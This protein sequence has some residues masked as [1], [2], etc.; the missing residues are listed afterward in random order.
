MTLHLDLRLKSL[1]QLKGRHWRA[2]HDD[3]RRVGIAFLAARVRQ[4]TP[5]QHRQLVTLTRILGPRERA[6][7]DE[8]LHGGTA[9]AV[10]DTLTDLGYW[11]DDSPKWID[12]AYHQDATRRAEGPAVEITV[13]PA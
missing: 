11:V 7:D 12:R 13:E 5:P 2:R 6:W 9:K 10:I 4:T 3:K 8:N 1:N